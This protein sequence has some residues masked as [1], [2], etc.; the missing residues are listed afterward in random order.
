MDIIL[1]TCLFIFSEVG[2]VYYSLKGLLV[3]FQLLR[4]E[5]DDSEQVSIA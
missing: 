3:E 4:D 1:L 5:F 2:T